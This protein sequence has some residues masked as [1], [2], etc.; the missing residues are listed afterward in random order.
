MQL[1]TFLSLASLLG[2]DLTAP[3]LAEHPGLWKVYNDSFKAA[4][5]V[6]LTHT[7]TP[8]IPVWIGFGSPTFAPPKPRCRNP[9]SH[10][11]LTKSQPCACGNNPF[12][13]PSHH[14]LIFPE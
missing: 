4:K 3:A 14:R 8:D 6:D 13:Q 1:K 5:Y 10:W 9:T 7:L 2:S 12:G 11:P